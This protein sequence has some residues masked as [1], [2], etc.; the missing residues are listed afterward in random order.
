MEILYDLTVEVEND[1]GT[2]TDEQMAEL[3]QH[4]LTRIRE[5]RVQRGN[6]QVYVVSVVVQD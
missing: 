1:Q 2:Q 4:F 6:A 5:L 3:L